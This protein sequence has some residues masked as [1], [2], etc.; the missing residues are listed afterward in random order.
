L[1]R[2]GIHTGSKEC[3]EHEK[4]T[5]EIPKEGR[6]KRSGGA[7]DSGGVRWCR[8]GILGNSIITEELSKI[9]MGIGF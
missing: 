2:G 1:R 7:L 4:Y 6:G 8:A 9:D 3:D 5:P